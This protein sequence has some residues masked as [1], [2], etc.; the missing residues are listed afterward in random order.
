MH[1]CASPCRRLSAHRHDIDVLRAK[2]SKQGC[3]HGADHLTC[4]ES[5]GKCAV[6]VIEVS[7][8]VEHTVDTDVHVPASPC[9]S[10][11]NSMSLLRARG[12]L[13]WA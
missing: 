12:R 9:A 10:E 11:Q 5:I 7:Q 1:R 13:P 3:L 8:K 6:L 2:E 4:V